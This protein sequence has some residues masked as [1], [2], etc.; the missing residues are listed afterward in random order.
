MPK[1][2]L[3]FTL[4]ALFVVVVDFYFVLF[5]VLFGLF[6][7]QVN[8]FTINSIHPFLTP[9]ILLRFHN[10]SKY[11]NSSKFSPAQITPFVLIIPVPLDKFHDELATGV[12]FIIP[13]FYLGK[14]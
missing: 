2:T 11:E 9:A 3:R 8:C 14:F 10:L 6:F 4:Y 13:P 1:Y 5:F 12:M 7:F